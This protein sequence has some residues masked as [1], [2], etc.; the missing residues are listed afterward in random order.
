[1]PTRHSGNF[2][3]YFD[4]NSR[5]SFHSLCFF[6]KL[7]IIFSILSWPTVLTKYLLPTTLISTIA[8]LIL[9]SLQS[10]ISL[11]QMVNN[12][13]ILTYNSKNLSSNRVTFY[14]NPTFW[15]WILW[16]MK[17]AWAEI[18]FRMAKSDNFWKHRVLS[19]L[20]SALLSLLHYI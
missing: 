8:A 9:A 6:I 1:M 5:Y 12:D 3:W 16:L 7:A 2:N 18:F 11:N 17:L 14:K 15:Y 13:T 4:D 20:L 10:Q 19:D